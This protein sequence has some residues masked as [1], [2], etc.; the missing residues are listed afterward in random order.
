[1]AAG[2]LAQR[3]K[4]SAPTA[5]ADDDETMPWFRGNHCSPFRQCRPHT[6]SQSREQIP[7][8]CVAHALLFPLR[9]VQ[10]PVRA[11]G[12]KMPAISPV[13]EKEEG[14]ASHEITNPY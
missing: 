7:L 9:S 1:M 12:S 2:P 6:E 4:S 10:V 8:S 13:G 14:G 5:E 11:P 3:L